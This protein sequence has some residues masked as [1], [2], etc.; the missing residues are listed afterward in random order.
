MYYY[1]KYYE[2]IIATAQFVSNHL[3]YMQFSFVQ[4]AR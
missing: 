3:Q 1:A 2:H 4:A